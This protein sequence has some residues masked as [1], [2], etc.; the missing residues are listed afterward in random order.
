[1][2]V[3]TLLVSPERG[4]LTAG[5]VDALTRDWGGGDTR[6]LA[7]AI[8]AEFDLAGR[9]ADLWT[10]WELLQAQGVDLV[11]QPAAGRRKRM[12]LADMDSTMIQ[13]ECI[14]ELAD[15]AGV[16]PR[17]AEITRRAM[18]GE[19]DFEGA[20][21]ERVGLLKGLPVSVIGKVLAERIT[22]TPGGRELIAT[23]HANGGHAVLV[24]G[25]F[26]S[27]TKP[28]A[29]HLGFDEN[30]ANTLLSA[31]GALTGEV[32]EPILGRA[33][34]VAALEEISARLGIAETDVIAV[35]DGANDL[36][37]LERAGTGVA[38]H[39]KPAVAAQCDV[40]VN[41]GDLTALLY[42]Q[43]YAREEFAA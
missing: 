8:A 34:K 24:S 14:D 38:L 21:R 10:R 4:G 13:Q 1:M 5:I 11:V 17:V 2:H 18:N 25:G 29:A 28:V 20:L 26:T 36:G 12:L 9:P 27:F 39:A 19:L 35:G 43:G 37:M 7:P 15:E 6:W 40:R 41:F 32:A 30:R 31:E 42:I 33:A 3:A 23:M 22:Y 16:G